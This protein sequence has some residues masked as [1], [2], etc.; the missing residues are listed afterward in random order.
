MIFA[1][2]FLVPFYYCFHAAR[3]RYLSINTWHEYLLASIDYW[4]AMFIDY[5]MSC[6]YCLYTDKSAKATWC[7]LLSS[8]CSADNWAF[9]RQLMLSKNNHGSIWQH[10]NSSRNEICCN[11]PVEPTGQLWLLTTSVIKE[12]GT[13]KLEEKSHNTNPLSLK[14]IMQR[15]KG[16]M[17]FN[18]E[19]YLRG[20]LMDSITKG[21]K[22]V[23]GTF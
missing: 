14:S 9:T 17:N 1:F 5:K 8:L 7:N 13:W 19:Q 6:S 21:W 23:N 18:H 12:S 22:R 3:T 2:G 20:Y 4:Q 15:T 11:N 10:D 16:I